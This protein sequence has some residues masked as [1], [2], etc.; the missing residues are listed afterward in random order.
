MEASIFQQTIFCVMSMLLTQFSA[1]AAL[2]TTSDLTPL[3]IRAA[4]TEASLEGALSGDRGDRHPIFQQRE[5]FE[6]AWSITTGKLSTLSEYLCVQ[7][8]KKNFSVLFQS[9]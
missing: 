8:K 5:S 3:T 4:L 9:S 2:C 1:T 6:G 7:K